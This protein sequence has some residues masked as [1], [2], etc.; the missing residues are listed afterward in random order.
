MS[1]A[2]KHQP[3][4][5][6]WDAD[7]WIALSIEYDS[8][9]LEALKARVPVRAWDAPTRRWLIPERCRGELEN[10]LYVSFGAFRPLPERRPRQPAEPY[11]TLG[12]LP[13]A[14]DVVIS[15]AYKALARERHPDAGGSTEA[16][17]RL[18]AARAAIEKIRR[19][20]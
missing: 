9:F 1:R 18:E 2:R 14:P 16:F 13:D 8:A 4:A 10:L 5:L 19:A 20:P 15:A 7:D 3:P 12:V 17:Q 6:T 11:A